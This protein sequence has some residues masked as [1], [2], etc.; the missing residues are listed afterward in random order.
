LDADHDGHDAVMIFIL[1]TFATS[2]SLRDTERY[3]MSVFE[4]HG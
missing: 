4:N 2:R 3:K 1:L